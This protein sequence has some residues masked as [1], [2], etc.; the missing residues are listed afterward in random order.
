MPVRGGG[1]IAVYK[2]QQRIKALI[3]S[4]PSG[5]PIADQTISEVLQAEGVQIARRTVAKYREQLGFAPTHQRKRAAP[6]VK[7]RA[8]AQV[9]VAA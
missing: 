2:V 7:P 5:R 9:A 8:Y 3:K 6:P 4:E 1:T